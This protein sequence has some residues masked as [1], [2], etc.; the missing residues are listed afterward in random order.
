MKRHKAERARGSENESVRQELGRQAVPQKCLMPNLCS[1][2]CHREAQIRKAAD[3]VTDGSDCRGR[4][5]RA[6]Q[7]ANAWR[8]ACQV[9]VLPTTR[10]L[11]SGES[12]LFSPSPASSQQQGSY[13]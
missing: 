10:G 6:E 8:A 4:Q 5:S 13:V 2:V 3:G 12:T 7:R 11:S 9:R 1:N